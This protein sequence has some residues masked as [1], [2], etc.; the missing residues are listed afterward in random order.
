M[1]RLTKSVPKY[2]LH[3]ATGQAV[4]TLAGRDHYLGPWKS[5]ASLIEY[6]RLV[7][8]W[9]AAGR[10]ARSVQEDLGITVSEVCLRYW[11][12]AKGYYVKN[13]RPTGTLAGIRVAIRFLRTTY[14]HTNAAEFGPLALRS[15]QNKMLEAG[16]S[17]RYINDNIDR[18]RRLFTWAVSEELIPGS[19]TQA[20]RSVPGLRKGRTAAKEYPPVPP[21]PDEIVERTLQH[22]P[23]AVS[24]MIRFQRLTGCRPEEVCMIRPCD[25]DRSEDVWSFRPESH[26]TEHHGRSRIIF[27]GPKA[28]AVLQPYLFRAPA[29]HC[30]SPKDS[31]EQRRKERHAARKTPLNQ[32]NRPGKKRKR[33][34]ARPPKDEYTTASYRRAIHRACDKAFPPQGELA[35]RDGET[36]K[37]WQAR[38]SE[39]Q[40]QELKEWREQNRWSPNQ[41]RHSAATEVRKKFGLEAA[42][43]TLGHAS[44]DVS[45]IYAE[46]DMAKAKE[47][48]R[49]VG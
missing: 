41:L 42:Q 11:K 39:E 37:G 5:K 1:P 16:Q 12:F 35:K 38:L 48:M 8:E 18:I 14:G 43:V 3:R 13:G 7:G 32:G 47:T 23:K 33:T 28:Q 25:I 36:I 2:R 31:E 49:Q 6:D 30:F 21:V 45:Q 19:V 4:V 26:K 20:L 46:R 9:L 15:M 44:A 40:A 22:T 24:D 29:R 17:R 10:P 27:I 34:P